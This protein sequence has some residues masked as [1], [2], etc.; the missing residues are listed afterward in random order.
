MNGE[1]A[2][3]KYGFC[4]FYFRTGCSRGNDCENAHSEQ[5]LPLTFK[6]M[7]C[8]QHPVCPQQSWCQFAHGDEELHSWRQW[9]AQRWQ[10]PR[11]RPP[12]LW[13]GS[14]SAAEFV[15]G[16]WTPNDIGEV[17]AQQDGLR[18][19]TGNQ[20]RRP[21][22]KT[23][24]CR[25]HQKGY[26]DRGSRCTFAHGEETLRTE[27]PSKTKMCNS[28]EGGGPCTWDPKACFYAHSTEELK[29]KPDR[30]SEE[31]QYH[32]HG[33]CPK[34][35]AECW[36]VHPPPP[37]V[38]TKLFPLLMFA[39]HVLIAAAPVLM[40]AVPVVLVAFFFS[41][42][43]W[44]GVLP[45]CGFA[46]HFPFDKDHRR[47]VL[48]ACKE[49]RHPQGVSVAYLH[50]AFKNHIKTEYLEYSGSFSQLEECV[51]GKHG[52]RRSNPADFL[53]HATL[54][55]PLDNELGVSLCHAIG[56]ENL[57]NV[58][59][60][61]LFVSWVWRYDIGE[62]IDALYQYCCDNELEPHKTYVWICFLC[63]NQRK[64][65][66]GNNALDGVEVF[67]KVLQKI[68]KMVCVL[69]NFKEPV[70]LRRA[71]GVYEVFEAKDKK[72]NTTVI[73]LP[74]ARRE[75]CEK[76]GSPDVLGEVDVMHAKATVPSDE[77]LIR[78]KISQAQ[79]GADN[80]NR[81]VKNLIREGLLKIF[82]A[83]QRTGGR[84]RDQ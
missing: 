29:E 12:E 30:K 20:R 16:C 4:S 55:D 3:K 46:L 44:M 25:H 61:N 43:F 42:V 50:A 71:W 65:L 6:T 76:H 74:K 75:F 60:A 52:Q 39:G 49:W 2:V 14:E 64:L 10:A 67:G 38:Y 24:Y 70:Y 78:S 57:E 54:R 59:N 77:K 63:N 23:E 19:R 34:G 80:V 45:V 27:V 5:E 72:I 68:G 62:F 79:G 33:N 58:G 1:Q 81:E 37:P 7:P 36:F 53:K 41:P 22:L 69:D 18:Q 21:P 9:Q 47:L 17:G 84:G 73:L 28:G 35:D 56:V 13:S 48:L 32:Q 51:W 8:S 83:F 31:C 40:A 82:D 11:R 26:C 66:L 15:P